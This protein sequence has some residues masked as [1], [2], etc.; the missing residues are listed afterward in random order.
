M[1]EFA[2]YFL[3]AVISALAGVGVME[4][5]KNFIKTEKT[6]IYSLIMPF[7]AVGCFCSIE[8]LPIGV[9]GSIMTIGI[10]QIDYQ[11]LVQGIQKV[12]KSKITS[13]SKSED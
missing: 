6:W 9:F 1:T 10:M 12:V 7:V 13:L 2:S 3:K 5:L 11:L 4:W 8:Y